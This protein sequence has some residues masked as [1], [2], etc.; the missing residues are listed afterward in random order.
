MAVRPRSIL[1]II[2]H[3]KT[4]AGS[5]NAAYYLFTRLAARGYAIHVCADSHDPSIDAIT[6]HPSADIAAVVAAVQPDLTIDWNF[7]YPADLHRMGGGVQEAFD[8]YNLQSYS[9]IGRAFKGLQMALRPK[10][11]VIA[12][13]RR[14]LTRPGAVFVGNSRFTAD[15]A[16][17]AGADPDRVH[18]IYNGVDTDLYSPTT[19]AAVRSDVRSR[20]G[21]E[22]DHVGGIFVAHNLRLKNLQLLR[23]VGAR[24]YRTHPN[25]RLLVAG[26]RR[27]KW[28]APW[29]I[30]MGA[31]SDMQH[32][33]AA[34]DFLLHPSFFD[35][36]PNAVLESMASGLPVLVSE[37]N[38]A[39]EIVTDGV[40]GWVL[41]VAGAPRAAILQRWTDAVVALM[42]PATRRRMGQAAR[43][44]A[45]TFDMPGYLDRYEALLA[46][47]YQAKIEA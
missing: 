29:L 13:Q 12:R 7:R 24:V 35:S 28:T 6:F 22:P 43:R 38:G 14:Q 9:G 40:D 42:D 31:I 27:P 47:I 44:Q 19:A 15:Q 46:S 30:Y 39:R 8:R 37:P 17:A 10:S 3:F 21:M 20:F 26:K 45:E 25:F 4:G 5:E 36:F 34:A 32:A 1:L 16:I 2:E 41:P 18:V 11:E 33:Y 23:D